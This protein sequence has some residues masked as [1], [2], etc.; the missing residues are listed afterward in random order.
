[1]G[2]DQNLVKVGYDRISQTWR[3]VQDD[4]WYF[5]KFYPL[6]DWVVKNCICDAVGEKTDKY[7]FLNGTMDTGGND[8]CVLIPIKLEQWKSLLNIL[9]RIRKAWKKVPADVQERSLSEP[10]KIESI[11]YEEFKEL[12]SS[13]FPIADWYR[14]NYDISYMWSVDRL[15]EYVTEICAIH[16]DSSGLIPGD[17]P[18]DKQV[19]ENL[20]KRYEDR[21]KVK[22]ERDAVSSKIAKEVKGR[23]GTEDDKNDALSLYNNQ[24]IAEEYWSRMH[25]WDAE[26]D[27]DVSDNNVLYEMCRAADVEDCRYDKYA[28]AYD[29]WY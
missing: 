23:Y 24:A 20:R 27:F 9:K 4:D 2:L 15:Y 21:E 26:H 28:F 11:E 6:H 10:G 1:M 22:L 17:D 8:N 7:G 19:L 14:D 29:P 25:Q 3:T 5:R 16:H 12:A 18:I 13:T